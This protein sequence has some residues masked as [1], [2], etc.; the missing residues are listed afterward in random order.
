V[1][2]DFAMLADGVTPRQDGK[3]D[4]YGAGWDTIFAPNVPAM[5]PRLILAV[6][7]LISRTEA[8]HPHRLEVIIQE[9]DGVEVGRALGP[10]DPLPEAVREQIPAGRQA[11]L[12]MVLNFENLVFPSFGSYHIVIQWDGNEARSPLRLI[13]SQPPEP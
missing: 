8:E 2:L 6:R 5:H 12:G 1:D 3:L 11:G 13:V 7:L 4:I 9:A 10:L